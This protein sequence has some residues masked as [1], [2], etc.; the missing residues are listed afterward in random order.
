MVVVGLSRP[1]CAIEQ[2]AES[3]LLEKDGL[4]RSIQREG[5]DDGIDQVS[6]VDECTG[7]IECDPVLP[8]M[9]LDPSQN[10]VPA[11]E[12]LDAGR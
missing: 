9:T 11:M 3:I 2:E 1:L 5:R 4:R 8:G 12:P 6:L 7:R 10:R